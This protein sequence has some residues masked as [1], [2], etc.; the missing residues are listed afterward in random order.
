MSFM[1]QTSFS[2]RFCAGFII[3]LQSGLILRTGNGNTT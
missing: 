2:L 1:M 3:S